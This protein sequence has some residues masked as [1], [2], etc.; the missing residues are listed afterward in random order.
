MLGNSLAVTGNIAF[1][2]AASKDTIESSTGEAD[3]QVSV[4]FPVYADSQLFIDKDMKLTWQGI[5][6]IFAGEFK[7]DLEDQHIYISVHESDLHKVACRYPTL[8]CAD[9]IHWIVS[10]T[11][12]E[13]MTL[14]N[15]SGIH[16]SNFREENYQ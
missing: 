16:I 5:K 8:P 12:L 13:A 15:A 1:K 7:E 9:I 6:D 14:S 2:R 4:N 11:D 10:D 3:E